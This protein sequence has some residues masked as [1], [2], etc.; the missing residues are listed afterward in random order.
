MMDIES[1]QLTIGHEKLTPQG[2]YPLL[3]GLSEDVEEVKDGLY[4]YRRESEGH[5]KR[6]DEEIAL[7]RKEVTDL[8][9][10]T[11]VMEHRI[12]EMSESV[13]GL[14]TALREQSGD[15][16]ALGAQLNTFQSKLGYYM[17]LL[18]IGVSVALVLFQMLVK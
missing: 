2:I 8:R 15:I 18:G 3:R 9:I 10:T 14:Q 16:K 4:D 11:G 6:I 1:R 7:L 13:K 5:F 12:T 17:T